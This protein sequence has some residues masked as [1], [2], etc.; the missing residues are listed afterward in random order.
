MPGQQACLSFPP[1]SIADDL[2]GMSQDLVLFLVSILLNKLFLSEKL[3][4]WKVIV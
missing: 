4:A 3:L 2:D 1:S